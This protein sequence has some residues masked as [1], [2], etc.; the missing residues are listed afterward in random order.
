MSKVRPQ[1]HLRRTT[2]G[3]D[4]WSIERLIDLSRNLPVKMV[5][6]RTFGELHE[7]HWYF[8]DPKLVPTPS[9][10]LGHMK[11]I[12]ET[13]VAFPIILDQA[14]RVMDGMHRIC[15]AILDDVPEIPAVQF[16]SDPDPDFVCT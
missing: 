12:S 16:A 4:A 10:I 14:G 15:R 9:S 1:Y 6:P 13:D 11:L 5:D 3:I 8:H 2:S 7:D